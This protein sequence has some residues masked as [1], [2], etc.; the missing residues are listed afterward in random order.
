MKNGPWNTS[1]QQKKRA[2]VVFL[3]DRIH[4]IVKPKVAHDCPGRNNL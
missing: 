3:L 1:G 2:K 4:F